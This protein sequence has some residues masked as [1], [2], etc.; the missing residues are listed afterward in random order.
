MK[1]YVETGLIKQWISLCPFGIIIFPGAAPGSPVSV[2][3]LIPS[4]FTLLVGVGT[5]G[6]RTWVVREP[7]LGDNGETMDRK[8]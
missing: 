7:W 3:G 1:L 8:S 2:R 5:A 6:S 4:F